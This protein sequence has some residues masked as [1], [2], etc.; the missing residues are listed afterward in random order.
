MEH[1]SVEDFVRQRLPEIIARSGGQLSCLFS[2]YNEVGRYDAGEVKHGKKN[3]RI[4]VKSG[5]S[6]CSTLTEI[7]LLNHFILSGQYDLVEK[8]TE[9]KRGNA[10]TA[11]R[12]VEHEGTTVVVELSTQKSMVVLYAGL[13]GFDVAIEYSQVI[14]KQLPQTTIVIL[15]CDCDLRRKFRLLEPLVQ[16]GIVND[17]VVTGRCGGRTAMEDILDSLI[18]QWP[19]S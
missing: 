3:L 17:V 2:T 15:A 13:H 8:I 10:S 1:F 9:G 14:R 7:G 12:Q 4:H 18:E 5:C 19:E 11:Q 16:S 6:P